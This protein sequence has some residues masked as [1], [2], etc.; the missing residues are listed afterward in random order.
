MDKRL[1]AVAACVLLAAPCSAASPAERYWGRDPVEMAAVAA[2]EFTMGSVQGAPD[3]RPPHTVT[4]PAYAIDK[5]E[6]TNARYREFEEWME[7]RRDHSLCH[8]AEPRGKDHRHKNFGPEFSGPNLP[9]TGVDWFDA[10]AYAGWAGK[11]LPTEAEWER[12]ARGTEARRYP[13]GQ[14]PE[15]ARANFGGAVGHP[16]PV[17]AYASGA[18]PEGCA[19]M[20]GN[21]WEWCLDWFD[22]RWYTKGDDL[23]PFGPD[24]GE[25]RV[26]RGGSF[27]DFASSVRATFRAHTEPAARARHIGFRCAR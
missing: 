11:R 15:P 6:V 14:S 8:H 25:T 3:E 1:L 10:F 22:P 2:G 4:L 18:S 21:V 5:L 24:R 20:A 16:T 19:D 13:W 17:G 12:A 23:N 9:V 7:R 27:L 26:L